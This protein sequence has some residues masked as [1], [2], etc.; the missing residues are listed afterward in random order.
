M[1]EGSQI[2]AYRVLKRIGEGGMGSVWLAEHSMI[3]RRAAIKVLHHEFSSKAEIVT[4]FFNEARAA[5]AIADPGIVQ[6]FDF[7]NHTDGSA[8]IVMELLDGEALD[9]RLARLGAL[10]VADAL[11][12][13]RQV[14]STL[15]AT[16]ARG[17]VHRDLKPENI[18]IVRDPEVAGGER[19]KVLDFGIAKLAGDQNAVKTHTSAVMGTPTYMSPEQCRGAGH[20][21]QR[22]DVYALGCV[23]Y[24]VLCGRPP[25]DAEGI[26]ELLMLHMREAPPPPSTLRPGLP[27]EVEQV[28]MRCL[29]K[30]PAERYASG[31]EL[32]IALGA[33][34]GS[35]PMVPAP[36]GS[37]SA[38]SAPTTLSSAASAGTQPPT[39]TRS[40]GLAIAGMAVIAAAVFFGIAFMVTRGNSDDSSAA[41]AAAAPAPAAK[42][43]TQPAKPAEPVAAA[44][45][46]AKPADPAIEL[47]ARTKTVLE[48]FTAWSRDHAGAPCPDVAT[49]G[50]NVNDPWGHPFQITCTNQPGDQIVGAV[51]AGPDGAPG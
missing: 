21:D 7:G 10:E 50:V 41:P 26:G 30:D 14:A 19:A 51:S 33:L 8:Y 27:R 34:T 1:V 39:V 44:P 18:F 29:A 40:R 15:G 43:P 4:R 46:A 9:T 24:R 36:R 11:R 22:A 38:A 23:L 37:Y 13:M 49:L 5:T 28:I 45:P 48:R 47:A 20:V 25:F 32:A 35:S 2:G 6:I 17:I 12:I 16:H 42:E 3:G 31:A